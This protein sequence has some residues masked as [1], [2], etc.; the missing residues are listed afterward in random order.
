MYNKKWI[1]VCHALISEFTPS[2][3]DSHAIIVELISNNVFILLLKY[4]EVARNC[5]TLALVAF[6]QTEQN[7]ANLSV[8]E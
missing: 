1:C 4:N 2:M 8:I 5:Y 7:I 6:I 3:T